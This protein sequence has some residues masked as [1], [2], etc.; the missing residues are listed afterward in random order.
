MFGQTGGHARRGGS[1]AAGAGAGGG[2][3]SA[4]EAGLLVQLILAPRRLDAAAPV[5][6]ATSTH[7]PDRADRPSTAGHEGVEERH[8]VLGVDRAVVVEV[9]RGIAHDES[10]EE[11]NEILA[12][13]HAIVT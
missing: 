13:D 3:M 5:W 10:I 8:E 2:W 12:V 7:F 1:V 4:I 6:N 11:G 9:G